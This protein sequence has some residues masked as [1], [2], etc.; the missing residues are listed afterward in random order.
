MGYS[1]LGNNTGSFNVA[2]GKNA[3]INN[4]TGSHNL[5]LGDSAGLGVTTADGVICIGA[6]GQDLAGSCYIGNIWAQPGG[7]QAV[8]VNSS[9]KLGLQV[10]SRRFKDEIKPME[11][12]SEVIYRLKPVSFRY[13][14]EIEP[15][16]PLCFG[17]I[18]E[19]VE[20]LNPDLAIRG[21]DGQVNSVR[22]DAVN[23]MLLNEFLKEHKKVEEQQA[24]I[25][26]L[27]STVAQQE[28][29]FAQ[30]EQQL[31]ALTSGLQKVSAQIEMIRATPRTLANK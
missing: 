8:Y 24:T 9:G 31:A 17:L 2:I 30:Q 18:A 20:K 13:K 21:S 7:S 19:E 5:A 11:D 27:K 29:H 16:R 14:P 15:T 25:A 28:E 23:A 12:A 6:I 3:L 22:Y 10:S 26:K 4:T 1:A